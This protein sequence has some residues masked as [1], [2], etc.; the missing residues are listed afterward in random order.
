MDIAMYKQG[1]WILF[2]EPLHP[3]AAPQYLLQILPLSGCIV[4]LYACRRIVSFVWHID[5]DQG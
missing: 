5:T 3:E 1:L 4:A 2:S